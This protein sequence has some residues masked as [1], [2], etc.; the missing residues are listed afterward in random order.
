MSRKKLTETYELEWERQLWY[1]Q[2]T[3]AAN[4]NGAL[5]EIALSLPPRI[6][7]HVFYLTTSRNCTEGILVLQWLQDQD[8]CEYAYAFSLYD[9]ISP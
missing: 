7:P 2:G 5:K 4:P 8:D 6:V 3:N 1:S 9:Y